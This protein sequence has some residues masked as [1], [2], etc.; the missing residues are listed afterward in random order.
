MDL[1]DFDIEMRI[2]PEKLSTAQLSNDIMVFAM[3]QTISCQLSELLS[4]DSQKPV[5]DVVAFYDKL[6]QSFF[7]K[8]RLALLA[9]Y[10]A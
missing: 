2:P 7:E 4:L 6:A 8:H 10:G 1:K 3:L 5:T 9:K